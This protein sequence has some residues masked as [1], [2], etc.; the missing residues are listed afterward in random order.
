MTT[1]AE[2][3]Q[4]SLEAANSE[5]AAALSKMTVPPWLPGFLSFDL[6]GDKIPDVLEPHLYSDAMDAVLWCLTM[7]APPNTVAYKAAVLIQKIKSR[8]P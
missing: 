8:K 1:P 5:R 7:F 2:A 3:V 6:D 4:A